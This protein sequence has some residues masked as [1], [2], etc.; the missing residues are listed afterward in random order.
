MPTNELI[1]PRRKVLGPISFPLLIIFNV[2]LTVQLLIWLKS[3]YYDLGKCG[4]DLTVILMS[5]R[6][7]S[8]LPYSLVSLCYFRV[9]HYKNF[10]RSMMK[11]HNLVQKNKTKKQQ[12]N[13]YPSLV[14]T[15]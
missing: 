1:S 8:I 9:S 13:K 15:R 3:S 7:T 12:L 11:S 14:L 4:I 5:Q 6:S 2:H 10:E